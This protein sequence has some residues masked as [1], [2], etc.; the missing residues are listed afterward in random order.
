MHTHIASR[1]LGK[2]LGEMLDFFK[3]ST[4]LF[5]ATGSILTFE[6][7]EGGWKIIFD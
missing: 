1:M 4:Y 7:K 2:Y 6:C 3:K 5:L